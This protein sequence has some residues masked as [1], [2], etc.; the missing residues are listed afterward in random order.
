MPWKKT[1]PWAKKR[2]GKIAPR[3]TKASRWR[4]IAIASSRPVTP[5]TQSKYDKAIREWVQKNGLRLYRCMKA[6][7]YQVGQLTSKP[8]PLETGKYR[9]RL[10][11][12]KGE[13]LKVYLVPVPPQALKRKP[14]KKKTAKKATP[15]KTAKKKVAKKKTA[16]KK[17]AKTAKGKRKMNLVRVQKLASA[18]FPK[19]KAKGSRIAYKTWQ[20]KVAAAYMRGVPINTIKEGRIK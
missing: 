14:S 16:K 11:G 3:K 5:I 7:K 10:V 20:K 12:K 2:T 13:K 18:S 17:T 19:K 4:A 9:V 6:G 1:N 8:Q 15:R